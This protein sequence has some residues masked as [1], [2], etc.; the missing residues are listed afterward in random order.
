MNISGMNIYFASDL[1]QYGYKDD[2]TPFIG[3][4]FFVE[5]ENDRGDR[6]RL[7]RTF[8]GVNTE[9]WDEG[10][11]FLDVRWYARSMCE[12]VIS[13]IRAAGKINLQHWN[14]ARPAYGSN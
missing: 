3:E 8:D 1:K 6:W 13:R 7:N 5:I 9:E 11:A 12:L 14:E 2:G 4:V 10:V